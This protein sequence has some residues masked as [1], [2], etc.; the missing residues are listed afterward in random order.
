MAFHVDRDGDWVADLECGH[1]RHVRHTP[2]WTNRKWI[3]TEKGRASFIG[4][5]LHCVTCEKDAYVLDARDR[6]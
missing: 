3:L 1:T 2:P 5:K 4:H 6:T